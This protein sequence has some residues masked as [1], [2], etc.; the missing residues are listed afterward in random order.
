[1]NLILASFYLSCGIGVI[2]NL[3]YIIITPFVEDVFLLILYYITVYLLSLSLCFL[4]LFVL[5]LYRSE[6][7][8]STQI[9][10]IMIFIFSV[11]IIALFFIPSAITINESTSWRPRWNLE[12]TILFLI[13]CTFG[14]IIP[15]LYYSI[16]LYQRLDYSQLKKRW[17]CFIIGISGYFFLCY[18]TSLFL[19]IG[20]ENLLLWALIAMPSLINL[21]LIYY[22]IGRQME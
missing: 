22:G 5:V 9:Q 2:F 1:M 20:H 19:Y 14:A 16:K 6:N 17:L 13:I 8:I 11:L 4:N 3:I 21:F 18:G 7:V 12:F 10:L 15:T